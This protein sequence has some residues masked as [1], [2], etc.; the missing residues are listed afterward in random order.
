MVLEEVKIGG[1]LFS[2]YALAVRD[3]DE[4]LQ[5]AVIHAA[6]TTLAESE[7]FQDDMGLRLL[8]WND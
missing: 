7:K 2:V 3:K 5:Q 6:K 8:A 4:K 1:I